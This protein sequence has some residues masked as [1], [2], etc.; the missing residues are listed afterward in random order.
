MGDVLLF[1]AAQ[2][3]RDDRLNAL[4]SAYN[5]ARGK[6]QASGDISDGIRAGK[7]W[8]AWLDAF[9]AVSA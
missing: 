7:A 2:R 6:A 3:E 4:W 9:R 1:D 5:E 8:A